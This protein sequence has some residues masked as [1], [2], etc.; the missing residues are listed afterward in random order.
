MQQNVRFRNAQPRDGELLSN[1]MS[2]QLKTEQALEK[3]LEKRRA[4]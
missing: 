3:T 2:L 1:E 4:A